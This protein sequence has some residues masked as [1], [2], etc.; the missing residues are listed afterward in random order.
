[1]EMNP[2]QHDREN[3][4][5]ESRAFHGIGDRSRSRRRPLSEE[6]RNTPQILNR[7]STASGP[8]QCETNALS[9]LSA[10]PASVFEVNHAFMACSAQKSRLRLAV[11]PYDGCFSL[12]GHTFP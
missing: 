4:W 8:I 1:M 6:R 3:T 7:T 11:L 9:S 10:R 5:W 2:L 12:Y